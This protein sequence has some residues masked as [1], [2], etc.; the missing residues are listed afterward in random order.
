MHLILRSS[1]EYRDFDAVK[2]VA[3]GSR[4]ALGTEPGASRATP[5][6]IEGISNTYRPAG[7]GCSHGES[8]QSRSD[9]RN[10]LKPT[11]G[12]VCYA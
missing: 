4:S 6:R 8:G 5:E 10:V 1:I 12:G 11:C 2:R 7:C 9:D 3:V